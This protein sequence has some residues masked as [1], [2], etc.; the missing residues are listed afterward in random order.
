[1][2]PMLVGLWSRNTPDVHHGGLS[3][4]VRASILED[5]LDRMTQVTEQQSVPRGQKIRGIFVAP[6]YYFSNTYSGTVAMG[7]MQERSLSEQDKEAVVASIEGIS[8]R[9]PGILIVPGTVAWKKSFARTGEYRFKKDKATGQRTTELKTISRGVKAEY[10]LAGADAVMTRDAMGGGQW[11]DPTLSRA[12][13]HEFTNNAG[14][15]LGAIRHA[16]RLVWPTGPLTY[17]VGYDTQV[18]GLMLASTESFQKFMR[19]SL[20]NFNLRRRVCLAHNLPH[21]A[22]NVIPTTVEKK[23]M[24]SSA[25]YMMRNIAYVCLDGKVRFKYAKRGD[26]H[27]AVGANNNTVFIPGAR[28]GAAAIEGI[29][30][31][32]EICLDHN[33]GFLSK[34][35][36]GAPVQVHIVSSAAVQNK[37]ENMPVAINGY[38]LHASSRDAW[39]EVYQNIG[40]TMRAVNT[41]MGRLIPKRS[42]AIRF[43]SGASSWRAARRRCWTGTSATAI[44]C[45]SRTPGTRSR[46]FRATLSSPGFGEV[47]E[48]L[49]VTMRRS[50]MRCWVV[51]PKQ[52]ATLDSMTEQLAREWQW[53]RDKEGVRLTFVRNVKP[54]RFPRPEVRI[55][56]Y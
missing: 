52:D 55:Y 19:Y 25:D 48:S 12:F 16:Y 35:R 26:Y 39:T 40:G 18:R 22:F 28:I 54:Q 3:T 37:P 42:A 49:K 53:W 32:F 43:T 17:D 20:A 4:L 56:P 33:L 7:G 46:S 15:K 9:H 24:A 27:E 29:T 21:E 10:A 50:G 47:F 2:Q 23:Q 51:G 34:S 6:E 31:G 13:L 5:A 45:R 1:M 30:F 14:F 41:A 8:A 36:A 38:Y 11:I 44:A